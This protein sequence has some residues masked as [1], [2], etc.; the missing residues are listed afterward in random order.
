MSENKRE[1]GLLT[2]DCDLN[3]NRLEVFTGGNGDYY[4]AVIDNDISHAVRIA[5]SGGNANTRIKLAVANLYRAMNNIR[6]ESNPEPIRK[7]LIER[8]KENPSSVLYINAIKYCS[9]EQVKILIQML[10]GY[11]NL[12][13]QELTGDELVEKALAYINDYYDSEPETIL[14]PRDIRFIAK[15][16]VDFHF[17]MKNVE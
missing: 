7:E 4:V 10:A 6:N 14:T 2:D 1:P 15:I 5:M 13:P 9:L 12:Q 8:V 17:E 11:F 16:M 3:K